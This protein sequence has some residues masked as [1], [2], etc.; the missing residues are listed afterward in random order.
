MK[1]L[2][3]SNIIIILLCVI[4]TNQFIRNPVFYL[5]SVKKFLLIRP[6]HFSCTAQH[7][8][9]IKYLWMESEGLI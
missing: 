1:L 7:I 5:T 8:L 4:Y 9:F 6:Q 3:K 2:I